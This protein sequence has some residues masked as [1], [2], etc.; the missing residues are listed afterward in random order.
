MP[1]QRRASDLLPPP[2]DKDAAIPYNPGT[3]ADPRPCVE[4][5]MANFRRGV[6]G[7]P[8]EAYRQARRT[9]GELRRAAAA[10]F[11]GEPHNWALADGHTATIDRLSNVI[12]QMY[13]RDI[14]VVSTLGEHVGGLGAF[15]AD[16]RVMVMQ[17]PVEQI[18]TSPGSLFF[19]S[20]FSYDTNRDNTAE[21]KALCNRIDNPVVIVDGSQALG[22]VPISVTALRCHAYVASAHKWLGGPH[23]TGLLYLR[24][25]VIEAWPT[26][27][28]AGE[29]ICDEPIGRWE[30]R[31]GQDFSRIPGLTAAIHDFAA[32][33]DKG[34][35]QRE[36]FIRGLRR[37]FGRSVRIHPESAPYGRV[38]VF[39]VGGLDVYEVYRLLNERGV[40]VKCIKRPD[41]FAALRV[42][43]PW[44]A[45]A[46]RVR[47][48]LD[49][50][51]SVVA[52]L[53]IQ[54]DAVI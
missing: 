21:I 48:S 54:Q 52:Q 44:W 5:A 49:V 47:D 14:T 46:A 2:D 53:A 28:R 34:L 15:A 26:P 43:F 3:L 25:D 7:R 6:R 36:R 16:P 23:G 17:V 18:A 45:S 42:G 38:V 51:R 29:P 41:G 50:L 40:S 32:H 30:P 13:G 22:Q 31:G 20:H 12:G 37:L 10:T 24:D 8:L 4:R 35:E 1:A 19:V 39:D 33:K 11:G 27:F 9:L